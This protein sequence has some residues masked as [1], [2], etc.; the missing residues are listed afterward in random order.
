MNKASGTK[1]LALIMGVGFF[2]IG[3]GHAVTTYTG[4]NF[5]DRVESLISNQYNGLTQSF[6]NV[7]T[8]VDMRITTSTY[9]AATYNYTVKTTAGG[10][11]QARYT[12]TAGWNSA[13]DPVAGSN[14]LGI[15]YTLNFFE[16]DA[17]HTF[18]IAKV[19][20]DFRLLTY[21]VDGSSTSSGS[22][23]GVP[24]STTTTTI[25]QSERVRVLPGSGF[26]SYQLTDPTKLTVTENAGAWEINGDNVDV[27]FTLP[28][29]AMMNFANTSVVKFQFEAPYSRDANDPVATY[30]DGDLTF[31]TQ[32]QFDT[33][34]APTPAGVPEP[35]SLALCLLALGGLGLVRRRK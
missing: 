1:I 26:V 31:I 2:G 28:S 27:N 4:F 19:L 17:G 3:Q 18:S 7:A 13:V 23:N 25:I 21:D 34:A 11:L 20:S 5:S 22:I 30:L 6:R 33:F 16:A 14:P 12:S 15:N 10:D 29:M 32:A 9:G 35:S 8:G 24:W